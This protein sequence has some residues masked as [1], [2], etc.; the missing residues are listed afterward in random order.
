[1]ALPR[2]FTVT[3]HPFLS[4]SDPHTYS[5]AYERGNP[6]SRNAIVYIGG[7][8]S[9]PHSASSLSQTLLNTL[10]NACLGYSIWESRMRSSYGGWGYS[11]LMNDVED[12]AALVRYLL[13]LG[14][15]KVVLLGSSTGTTPLPQL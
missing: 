15:E 14:K 6:S 4:P 10:D 1:M 11:S 3:V 12:I 9:G 7:L 13:G 5:C 2:P 8:T